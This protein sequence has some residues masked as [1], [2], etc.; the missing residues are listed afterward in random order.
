MSKIKEILC[1][2]SCWAFLAGNIIYDLLES[3]Q[4]NLRCTDSTVDYSGW[5]FIPLSFMITMLIGA[6]LENSVGKW[7]KT[8]WLFFYVLS[9]S[10]VF[11]YTLLDAIHFHIN[12]YWFLLTAAAATLI[13]CRKF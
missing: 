13:R 12:D 2:A 8:Q 10:M 1:L 3:T 4:E 6:M 5:Y 7:V 11:K 9:W